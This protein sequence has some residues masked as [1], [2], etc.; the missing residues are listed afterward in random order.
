MTSEWCFIKQERAQ[1]MLP[2]PV[3]RFLRAIGNCV[4]NCKLMDKQALLSQDGAHAN[5]DFAKNLRA[6]PFK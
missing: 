2:A 1:Q 5:F 3:C 4:Y 6:S